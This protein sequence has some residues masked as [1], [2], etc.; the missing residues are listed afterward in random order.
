MRAAVIG[1]GQWGQN[2]VATLHA[3]DALS[4]VVEA[5]PA[6]RQALTERYPG[7]VVTDALERVLPGGDRAPDG[8]GEDGWLAEYDWDAVSASVMAAVLP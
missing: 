6:R 4:V 3:L 1:A 2:L 8:A 7:L 5:D